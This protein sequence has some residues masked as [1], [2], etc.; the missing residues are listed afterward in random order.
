L[1]LRVGHVDDKELR[2]GTHADHQLDRC[3]SY[4]LGEADLARE[5]V[6]CFLNT[7]EGKRRTRIFGPISITVGPWKER[8]L[9][10]L[11]GLRVVACP[12]VPARL[13]L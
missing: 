12:L 6:D 3:G 8:L 10:V 5:A 4:V 7:A 11:P 13:I 9:I 2:L 1:V